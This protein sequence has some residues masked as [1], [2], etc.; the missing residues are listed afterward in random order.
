M[1]VLKECLVCN[2]TNQGLSFWIKSRWEDKE[3]RESRISCEFSSFDVR[4]L[5]RDNLKLNVVPRVYSYVNVRVFREF[6]FDNKDNARGEDFMARVNINDKGCYLRGVSKAESC[7]RRVLEVFAVDYK[8][9]IEVIYCLLSHLDYFRLY[10]GVNH[11]YGLRIRGRLSGVRIRVVLVGLRCSGSVALTGI[12]C[13]DGGIAPAGI[14][15]GG[16]VLVRCRLRG[17][18]LITI[19]GCVLSC[20]LK[21]DGVMRSRC[22]L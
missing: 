21:D 17:V 14:R 8:V 16:G 3:I 22:I 11:G 10:G 5:C 13:G 1:S 6:G 7:L 18:S 4:H 12:R 9:D 2:K 19:G 15:C 20:H